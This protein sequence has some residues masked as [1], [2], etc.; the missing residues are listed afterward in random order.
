M[1]WLEP[2]YGLST[3]Q[4]FCVLTPE[5]HFLSVLLFLRIGAL[6][7]VSTGLSLTSKE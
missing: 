5:G 3:I 2:N 6:S 4:G 7:T 1:L